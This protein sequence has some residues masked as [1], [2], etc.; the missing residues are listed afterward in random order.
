VESAGGGLT[1]VASGVEAATAVAS[2]EAEEATAEA[3]A[4]ET[5]EA[6]AEAT[7]EDTAPERWTQG[8]KLPNETHITRG[9]TVQLDQADIYL[10]AL[11]SP[12]QGMADKV[13]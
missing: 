9:R 11:K 3:T 1:A 13:I 7:A 10:H 2:E 4:E 8:L 12:N 5:A 6:T